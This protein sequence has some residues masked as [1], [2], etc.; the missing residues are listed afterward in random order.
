LE[1]ADDRGILR[2]EGALPREELVEHEAQRVEIALDGRRA[3]RELLRGH[4]GRR[5]AHGAVAR[6]LLGHARE[7]EVRDPD[8]P[9]PVD[10]DVRGLEIP[11]D[12][13]ALVRGGEPEAD[14]PRD[15]DRLVARGTAQTTE[16]GGEILAVDVL[17]DDE[18][19]IVLGGDV[20]RAADVRVGDAAG[21]ADFLAEAV[22]FGAARVDA[23]GRNLRA[24]VGSA[25]GR[26][27]VDLAHASLTQ[28]PND[29]V[30]SAEAGPGLE[31]SVP[32]R[33]GRCGRGG[34]SSRGTDR[35]AGRGIRRSATARAEAA[36]GR[37]IGLARGAASHRAGFLRSGRVASGDPCSGASAQSGTAS[38]DGR[39][40][41][42][43]NPGEYP[44]TSR[45]G[46][47]S[48]PGT[49]RHRL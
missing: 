13:P 5:A 27:A 24:T 28:Q 20:V 49:W 32:R 8:A 25:R 35:G 4:V 12:D 44:P 11:V 14:L 19:L 16:H 26:R 23:G 21:D 15:L 37:E 48:L 47:A 39:A 42:S 9:A 17:H 45:P 29:A 22:Q 7:P 36:V 31:A 1:A 40:P 46:S 3:A 6:E 33:R 18:D 30:A 10:H 41:E 38:V 43:P 34:R 2:I